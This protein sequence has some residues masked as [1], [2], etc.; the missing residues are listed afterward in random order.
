[1]IDRVQRHCCKHR[2]HPKLGVKYMPAP[3][4][5]AGMYTLNGVMGSHS[6]GILSDGGLPI[7]KSLI[8][9]WHG[10][11]SEKKASNLKCVRRLTC[12]D[13]KGGKNGPVSLKNCTASS[14]VVT[15]RN[16]S[17]SCQPSTWNG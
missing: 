10:A 2:M 4:V 6:A 1:M 8:I 14:E 5:M 13:F 16:I 12:L 11:M 7:S 9:R 15:E 3:P 17:L